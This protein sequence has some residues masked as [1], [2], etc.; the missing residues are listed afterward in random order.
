MPL[1]IRWFSFSRS[2]DGWKSLSIYH[3]ISTALPDAPEEPE[4]RVDIMQTLAAAIGV[5][6]P[7]AR[8]RICNQQTHF[9]DTG[10]Y[11]RLVRRRHT[12]T[13]RINAHKLTN[14]ENEGTRPKHWNAR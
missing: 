7:C 9:S 3:T 14:P 2:L 6:A 8:V 10:I 12:R 11:A 4:L 13:H 5:N 1:A